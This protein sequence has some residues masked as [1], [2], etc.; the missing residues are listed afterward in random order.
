[1][2][3]LTVKDVELKGK[4]VLVRVDFNVPVKDGV[5]TNDNRITAALPTIKYI[6]EQG[7]RAILFSHLGRVKEEADK[8]GKSLAPVAADLAAKLGQDVKFIPGVTRGAELEAAVNALEDGQVLLVENTRFE[9]VDGKK[10]SKN[11]PELGKYWASLGD[12][13]FVNDA[14]GTAHRAHA[15]NVG[16]SANVEKAVAGFLLENEIAYIQEAV[17]NPERPFVAILGGSKVSDKIGVIEN[18]LEKADKVL[19]GG[20]MTYTFFKAQGI[21]IG[22]S[23]VEEDKLDVAKALLEK[24][25]GKLILPVDSKEANAF[26][27]YTEVKYTE[28]EAIDPGFLGLD[29]G[30]KSIAKFDEALTGAKTVVWNGPMGVFENPDFQAGT[31]GVMDAIVKQPGVKSIIGGGDSA[32]AAINLGYADKFSWISTGGGASMELLEGK[33]LPGLAALTEK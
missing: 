23:L 11:D 10:E 5:I 28:G 9:D 24:S 2:A 20:G 13:I 25:N 1:M 4:K 31:I 33:E 22:N 17:E 26:A 12:G 8:E 7:G 3:K 29:I 16:I 15:S 6:L 14:F 18:L 30:P 19:I 32:A 21:E 27:D